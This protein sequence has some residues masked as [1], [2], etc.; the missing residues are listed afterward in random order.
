MRTR[1]ASYVILPYPSFFWPVQFR[2]AV[3]RP[4]RWIAYARRAR[5]RSPGACRPGRIGILRHGSRRYL[6]HGF[7]P[8]GFRDARDLEGSILC[9]RGSAHPRGPGHL[10]PRAVFVAYRRLLQSASETL[11]TVPAAFDGHGCS[12]RG[13]CRSRRLA[14]ARPP[15][16]LGGRHDRQC[17][18]HASEPEG[19]PQ[20]RSQKPGLGFPLIRVVVL[21]TLA[22]ATLI[23]AAFGPCEGKESGE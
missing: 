11:R 19:Y 15:G 17:S 1:K 20:S 21:L 10:G 2:A 13:R 3:V 8:L 4:R 6:Q 22:T 16:S 7:G 23:D 9:G 14:L 12:R 18:R 5:R